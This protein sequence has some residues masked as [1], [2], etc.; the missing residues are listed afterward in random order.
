MKTRPAPHPVR[1]PGVGSRSLSGFPLL[2][3]PP[4]QSDDFLDG[5]WFDPPAVVYLLGTLAG[6][7]GPLVL[8]LLLAT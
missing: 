7:F 3:P 5:P 2:V 8:A 6:V 4:V 1:R